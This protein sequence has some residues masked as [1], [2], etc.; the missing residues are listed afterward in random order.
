MFPLLQTDI[1]FWHNFF[2]ISRCLESLIA[3]PLSTISCSIHARHS[4]VCCPIP[5]QPWASCSTSVLVQNV[6]ASTLFSHVCR[7]PTHPFVGLWVFC[8]VLLAVA[9]H[10]LPT[11]RF[12][13]C[14]SHA[15]SSS[16]RLTQRVFV[17]PV[18]VNSRNSSVRSSLP[19]QNSSHPPHV[20]LGS[21]LSMVSLQAHF[22]KCHNFS[23]AIL[24]PD[25]TTRR[26]PGSLHLEFVH[27]PCTMSCHP[28]H[29]HV[30]QSNY[31]L[32]FH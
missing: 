7:F 4:S 25:R 16:R 19:I 22:S 21:I 13:N 5:I 28:A 29:Q 1:R 20:Q 8:C 27:N 9:F 3:S 10:G 14:K 30:I 2:L 17:A 32:V 18:G 15:S 6:V 23:S 12:K 26:S 24:A 31:C 11:H